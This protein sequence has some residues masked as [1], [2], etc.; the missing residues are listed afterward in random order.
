MFNRVSAVWR[1]AMMKTS[2]MPQKEFLESSTSS[3]SH[4]NRASKIHF[5]K[6]MTW[7]QATPP[8]NLNAFQRRWTTLKALLRANLIQIIRRDSSKS[9]TSRVSTPMSLWEPKTTSWTTPLSRCKTS[10]S[11]QIFCKRIWM[12]QRRSWLFLMTLR[13]TRGVISSKKVLNLKKW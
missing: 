3:Q 1:D 4:E 7:N 10:S 2:A 13:K 12:S 6:R 8:K 9:M 5:S 11:P